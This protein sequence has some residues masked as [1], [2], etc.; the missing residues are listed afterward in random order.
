MPRDRK[1]PP[2][3]GPPAANNV[4]RGSVRGNP[5]VRGQRDPSGRGSHLVDHGGLEVEEHAAGHVLAG[6][7]LREEGVEGVVT[8]ADGLVGGHLAIGLDAVLKA[9][10]LPAGVT[11]LDTCRPERTREPG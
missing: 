8:A 2:V 1:D 3:A 9:V 11:D 10:E 7:G 4:E 6:T 5:V